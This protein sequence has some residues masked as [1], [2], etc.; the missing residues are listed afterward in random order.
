MKV[1]D[2]V[3]TEALEV[4]ALE[5]VERLE[6]LEGGERRR[7]RQHLPATVRDR[8]GLTP[9]GRE[10]GQVVLGEPPAGLADGSGDR[11]RDRPAGGRCRPRPP[12]GTST[13]APCWS[14]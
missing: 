11:A 10:T 6:H 3:V 4:V 5:N 13:A 12:G 14:R 2:G 7:H 1:V 9:L 8:D